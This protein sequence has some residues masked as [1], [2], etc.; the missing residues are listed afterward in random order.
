LPTYDEWT[1]LAY[2]IYGEKKTVNNLK[3]ST[4]WYRNGTDDY[5]FAALPSGHGYALPADLHHNVRFLNAGNVSFWWSATEASEGNAVHGAIEDS[6]FEHNYV[7]R[8]NAN[9]K[10]LFS[11]R[12][13]QN[14]EGEQ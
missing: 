13:V 8:G 3:S 2:Y 9:K 12:C 1:T 10:S 5:G 14:K 4:G 11:V 6:E 7:Y